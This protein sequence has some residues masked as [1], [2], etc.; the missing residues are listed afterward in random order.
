M[1]QSSSSPIEGPVERRVEVAP[2]IALHVEERIGRPDAVPFVLVH[3]L[4]SNV[5]LW[6]GVAERLHTLGRTVYAIDQRGHGRADAPPAGYELETAVADLLSL[7]KVLGLTR[8]VLAGQSWGGNVVLELGWRHPDVVRGI[9]CVDGGVIELADWFP[10]WEDCL[11]AMTPPRLDHLTLA[12]LEARMK[13]QLPHFSERAISAYLHCFRERPDGTIEPR[14]QRDRHLNIV[15]S[16]WENR[17]SVRWPTL[18]APTLLLLADSGDSKRTEAKRR[19]E[20]DALA[21]AAKVQSVWFSPGHHDLH[22]E[23][24]ERVADILDKAV[25]DGFFA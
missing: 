7:I 5:R 11:T 24:P 4:A 8:P 12:Q 18:K 2:G 1:S 21:K 20:V 6:D 15:R 16:L 22:L 3:G 9:A 17:P 14:L 13:A 23:F 19:A 25:R 10:T